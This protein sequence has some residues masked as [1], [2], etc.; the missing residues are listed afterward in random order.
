M[1]PT[2]AATARNLNDISL[3]VAAK[4]GGDL[5]DLPEQFVERAE[6]LQHSVE[7][8]Y[9]VADSRD[10][11][12][13]IA[14]EVG[15][16]VAGILSDAQQMEDLGV[17]EFVAMWATSSRGCEALADGMGADGFTLK[18]K[19]Q[20]ALE[21]VDAARRGFT[22]T[23]RLVGAYMLEVALILLVSCGLYW[24]V[25]A[26]VNNRD[27]KGAVYIVVLLIGSW[28]VLRL[29][30]LA[31]PAVAGVASFAILPMMFVLTAVYSVVIH[32]RAR[33]ARH[34]TAVV[35]V[36]AAVLLSRVLNSAE[37][38]TGLRNA[39]FNLTCAAADAAQLQ[40]VKLAD[41]RMVDGRPQLVI[42]PEGMR[43]L[44]LAQ[45]ELI[46]H[47]VVGKQRT[48][49]STSASV[50]ARNEA[51]GLPC[52]DTLFFG[53]ASGTTP[54]THGLWALAVPTPDGNTR[55]FLDMEGLGDPERTPAEAAALFSFTLLLSGTFSYHFKEFDSDFYSTIGQLSSVVS[56]LGQELIDADDEYYPH[57]LNF[58]L[59][60]KGESQQSAVQQPPHANRA[61]LERLFLN[62]AL[63]DS[64]ALQGRQALLNV[65]NATQ[66]RLYVPHT[67]S[68]SDIRFFDDMVNWR[69]LPEASAFV[70]S[71]LAIKEDMG[72]GRKTVNGNVMT[73]FS[74][75]W[76][77]NRT[78][79]AINSADIKSIYDGV[80]FSELH[81]MICTRVQRVVKVDVARAVSRLHKTMPLPLKEFDD[82]AAA[83]RSRGLATAN[84][85]LNRANVPLKSVQEPCVAE[86]G[87]WI[88]EKLEEPT[89]RNTLL[90]T[91]SWRVSRRSSACP[92]SQT[93]SRVRFVHLR[94]RWATGR[95]ARGS[96]APARARA[97][98][99]ACVATTHRSATAGA[100]ATCR[101]AARSAPSMRRA[102]TWASGAA[103]SG[104]RT[105]A[106]S[107][108]PLS[109]ATAARRWT[110]RCAAT[111]P[112]QRESALSTALRRFR[113]ASRCW[114]RS[115][116]RRAAVH[117]AKSRR[118][119]CR[120]TAG[121]SSATRARRT[122]RR[123][124]VPLRSRRAARWWPSTRPAWTTPRAL[125]RTPRTLLS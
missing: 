125:T 60:N 74:V 75:E 62:R 50:F 12:L 55:V 88:D 3:R 9:D 13:L 86:L 44:R 54:M 33:W 102:G 99:T 61:L 103:A 78:A 5:A 118:T 28:V 35:I 32:M 18:E 76:L 84:D 112:T 38:R 21:S 81:E 124:S 11:S 108:D 56:M 29:G 64:S 15:K 79:S 93:V 20:A 43:Q 49:K 2:V 31:Y 47:A 42:Q 26:K 48:Y 17:S 123:T 46:V 116:K 91:F 23:T 10:G 107:R 63:A 7:K 101:C 120:C 36:V 106:F 57:R 83:I 111:R 34:A 40:P 37:G 41:V 92:A 110:T 119:T 109:A 8:I 58:V 122:G 104:P 6:K 22:T 1:D 16:I 114:R 96:V 77:V 115:Q 94:C 87:P 121:G 53:V 117:A 65:F 27:A 85:N 98:S 97:P 19:A 24:E 70:D 69:G 67:A 73:G 72:S 90:N 82:E 105:R 113:R 25:A 45:G 68:D 80:D 66:M 52:G 100:K 95:S 51:I 71:M 59:F 39:G 89:E 30:S 14:E 4:L